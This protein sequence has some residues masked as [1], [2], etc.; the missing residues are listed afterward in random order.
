MTATRSNLCTPGPVDDIRQDNAH[1]VG[2]PNHQEGSGE[3][4]M[5]DTT[6]EPSRRAD[7]LANAVLHRNLLVGGIPSQGKTHALGWLVA[8]LVAEN[9]DLR[10]QLESAT[11]ELD[12][13]NDAVVD[14]IGQLEEA[15]VP[16]TSVVTTVGGA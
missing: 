16:V 13:A 7:D 9:T 2:A 12:A 4:P 15:G 10:E 1:R 14:L 11:A 8:V 5:V 3:N 6:P